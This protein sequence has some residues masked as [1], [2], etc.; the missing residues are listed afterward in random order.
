MK[1]PL[2][3]RSQQ[4]TL[5]AGGLAFSLL[6]VASGCALERGWTARDKNDFKSGV[7]VTWLGT[8]QDSNTCECILEAARAAYP[9][10]DD[11][12][13]ADEPSS[14]LLVGWRMCG[15]GVSD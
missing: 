14:A 2:T 6:L 8:D 13:N 11:F 1:P 10:A 3:S 15:V 7:C 12:R 4:K 9:S 5:L